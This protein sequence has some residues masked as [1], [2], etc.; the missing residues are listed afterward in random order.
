ML[1]DLDE[2][3]KSLL[4]GEKPLR[5]MGVD[6]SF[7][8]PS[9]EWS[10]DL[11]NTTTINCYLFDIHERRVLREEGWQVQGRRTDAPTRRPPPL[12]FEMTYLITVWTNNVEDEHYLLWQV[13]ETLMDHPILPEQYLQGELAGHEWPISTTIAQL[14]GVLKSPGE[15]WTALENQLKPSLS[16]TV[17]LG[18]HRRAVPTEPAFAPPVLSHGIRVQL[19]EVVADGELRLDALFTLP[20]GGKPGGVTVSVADHDLQTTTD[21]Q[22]RFRLSGLPPGRYVLVAEIGG[23]EQRRP[24]VI[25]HRGAADVTPVREVVLDQDGAPAPGV[26]IRVEGSDQSAVSD[27]QGRFTLFLAPGRYTLLI[28]IGDEPQRREI[29]VRHS[30]TLHLAQSRPS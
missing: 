24:L 10:N 22:G 8:I 20:P 2:T 3:I 29:V 5:E 26:T 30:T 27:A 12:F 11:G 4:M 6:V 19:P 1:R 15:F 17:T 23:Q 9:R 28:E 25:R 13:L 7:K 14:E 21:R 18:R 16:Y